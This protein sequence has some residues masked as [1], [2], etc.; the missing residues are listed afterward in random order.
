VRTP[1]GAFFEYGY[2]QYGVPSFSTPGWGLTSRPAPTTTT[3]VALDTAAAEAGGG[4]FVPQGRGAGGGRQGGPGT[5]AGRGGMAPAEAGAGGPS[6]IDLRLLRWMDAE[7]IDGFV[8]WQPY[9]HPTLGEVEI[10]GFKPYETTNP[11]PARIADLGT[12]HAKFALYLSSLFPHVRIAKAEVTNHGGGIFR[13][14]AEVVNTGYL[15]TSLAHGAVARAVKPTMVQLGVDPGDI[16]AG[17]DKTNFFQV[18]PGSGGLQSYEW[19]V[20]GKAGTAVTLKVVSQKGGT[21]TAT[22]KLQ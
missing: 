5:A 21:D 17:N 20:K 8:N 6:F 13:I 2:Y 22:L 11:P 15:P 14:K 18:L 10:G 7:K 12:S 3:S 19:I 4:P 9:K 1:A 16:I